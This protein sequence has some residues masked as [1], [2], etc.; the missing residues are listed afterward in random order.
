MNTLEWLFWL[1]TAQTVPRQKKKACLSFSR[2]AVSKG[3]QSNLADKLQLDQSKP[4]NWAILLRQ[5]G[6]KWF[7]YLNPSY[8]S[9][10]RAV[11]DPGRQALLR[12]STT[13]APY[14][15]GHCCSIYPLPASLSV[16]CVAL[17]DVLI[18]I[19]KLSIKSSTTPSPSFLG[20]KLKC[21]EPKRK[22]KLVPD[23]H[24]PVPDKYW[25]KI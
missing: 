3:L 16:Q 15:R 17:I 1:T 24:L 13:A 5:G 20:S 8:C 18:T 6:E 7:S 14:P 22:G 4:V 2:Q 11:S 19:E 25:L 12:F 21:K 23:S 10:V 9:H